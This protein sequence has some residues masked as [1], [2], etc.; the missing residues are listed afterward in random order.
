MALHA[1]IFRL[2]YNITAIQNYLMGISS[3]IKEILGKNIF[4]SVHKHCINK[5]IL[6]SENNFYRTSG[7]VE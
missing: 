2:A 6:Y 1:T 5:D 3:L 4:V 7:E